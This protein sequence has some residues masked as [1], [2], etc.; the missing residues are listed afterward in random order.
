M[1]RKSRIDAAGALHHVIGR[2]IARGRIFSS[3]TDRE[4][5]L[6]R[7]G[8]VI[9]DGKASCY[10][11]ALIPNHFHLLLRTGTASLSTMMRRL[12]TGYATS[13]NLRHRRQGHLFQNR[14]KSILC[15]E[16][17]YLLELVRYIHLNPLRAGLVENYEELVRYP[18]CGHGVILGRGQMEWQ[19]SEFIL[20][21]FGKTVSAARRRYSEFVKQGVDV[22]RRPDL[23]GGG[24]LR[25]Q[26]GWE[27]VKSLREAGTYQKGDERILGDRDFVTQ[28]LSEADERY[29]RRYRLRARGYGLEHVVDRVKQLLHLSSAE[30]LDSSKVRGRVEARSL[31]CYWATKELAITQIDLAER[32][33]LSQSAVSRAVRRGEVLMGER[34]YV[35]E[36]EKA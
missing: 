25:S 35:L 8:D 15:Q 14:Y 6:N 10:A 23:I 34:Q 21:Q 22:G 36:S 31:L 5:F 28:V 12:L 18:Y 32:L 16:E 11:W 20:G 17:R 27:G 3:T 7:L 1:P 33:G 26:G 2:G 4:D 30:V 29:A 9:R 19:D 24:L 13:F